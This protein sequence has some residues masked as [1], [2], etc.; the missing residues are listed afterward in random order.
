MLSSSKIARFST[1]GA[2]VMR[3]MPS[4]R[5]TGLIDWTLEETSTKVMLVAADQVA[6]APWIAPVTSL[7]ALI[8]A[9]GKV[10]EVEKAIVIVFFDHRTE[11]FATRAGSKD[12]GWPTPVHARIVSN[13]RMVFFRRMEIRDSV[14]TGGRL[15]RRAGNT[16]SRAILHFPGEARPQ[17]SPD[18]KKPALFAC[19][20]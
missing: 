15:K 16:L 5:S 18:N 14:T 4:A 7:P 2:T 17:K 11:R 13:A 8:L 1:F 9:F 3:L 6:R 10:S 19:G 20:L 12:E